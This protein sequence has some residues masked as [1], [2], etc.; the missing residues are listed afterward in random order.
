MLEALGPQNL[1]GLGQCAFCAT[2]SVAFTMT[3]RLRDPPP[4][5]HIM[6]SA[7]GSQIVIVGQ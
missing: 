6:P 4:G 7:L 1:S 3:I 5:G 2:A